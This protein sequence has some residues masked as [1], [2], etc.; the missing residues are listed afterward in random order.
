M[1]REACMHSTREVV[2][3]PEFPFFAILPL[4]M[5]LMSLAASVYMKKH[6]LEA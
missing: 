6:T 4:F 2:I 5:I 3:I 1:K